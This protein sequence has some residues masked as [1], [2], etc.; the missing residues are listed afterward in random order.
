[1]KLSVAKPRIPCKF[2]SLTLRK[3]GNDRFTR[4]ESEAGNT[5]IE[6]FRIQ[7]FILDLLSG[8]E[9]RRTPEI[10]ELAKE[11]GFAKRTTELA[12]KRLR[13]AGRITQVS[14]GTY[15]LGGTLIDEIEEPEDYPEVLNL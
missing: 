6:L 12:L 3:A 10:L 14:R 1:V 8:G 7:D 9:E 5:G 13:E 4:V 2:K 15:T 11:A